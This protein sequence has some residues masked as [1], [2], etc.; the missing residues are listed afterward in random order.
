MTAVQ[1]GRLS[2]LPPEALL[3]PVWT[4]SI[5]SVC[6]ATWRLKLFPLKRNKFQLLP[7]GGREAGLSLNP[8]FNPTMS[9]ISQQP[10]LKLP[11]ITARGSLVGDV[12]WTLVC[13]IIAHADGQHMARFYVPQCGTFFSV[14]FVSA[15]GHQE[16]SWRWWDRLNTTFKGNCVR[17]IKLRGAGGGFVPTALFNVQ[18]QAISGG[19]SVFITHYDHGFIARTL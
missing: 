9:W 14:F 5:V 6:H 19:I 2:W 18:K 16:I 11:P 15:S 13:P 8:R 7:R 4:G 3:N 17:A 12:R 10:P 1:L